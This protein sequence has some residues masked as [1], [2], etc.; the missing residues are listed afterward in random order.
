[1]SKGYIRYILTSKLNVSEQ[2]C[3]KEIQKEQYKSTEDS[4]VFKYCE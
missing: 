2:N 4:S 3:K 1:M